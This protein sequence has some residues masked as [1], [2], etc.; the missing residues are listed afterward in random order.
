M[1]VV[2]AACTAGRNLAAR[3]V[4][5]HKLMN[6]VLRYALLHPTELDLPEPEAYGMSISSLRVWRILLSYG[7]GSEAFR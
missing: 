6:V 1:K 3:L 7:L 2:L 5:T 4:G